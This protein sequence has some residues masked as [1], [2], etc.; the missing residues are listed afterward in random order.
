MPNDRPTG[1]SRRRQPLASSQG[2]VSYLVK[3]REVIEQ[4]IL[5]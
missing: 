4:L 5:L 3:R 1:A 2:L